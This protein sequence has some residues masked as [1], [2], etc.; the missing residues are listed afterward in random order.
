MHANGRLTAANLRADDA[1]LLARLR[2]VAAAVHR[3]P[4][5]AAAALAP[6]VAAREAV[7]VADLALAFVLAHPF[8]D[9]ALSGAATTAQ[10]A[11]HVRAVGMHLDADTLRGLATVAEAPARYWSV[12]A[13][14]PWT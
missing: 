3:D 6:H 1:P 13:S 11:S 9:V 4:R 2:D 12:R 10:L 14:L 7:D 8:I 5:V